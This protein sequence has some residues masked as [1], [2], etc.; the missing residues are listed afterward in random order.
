MDGGRNVQ[1]GISRRCSLESDKHRQYI[2]PFDA[3]LYAGSK[4]EPYIWS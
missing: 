2:E 4:R 3:R 1:S